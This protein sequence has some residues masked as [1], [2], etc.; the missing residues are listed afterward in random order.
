[1]GSFVGSFTVWVSVTYFLLGNEELAL[2]GWIVVGYVAFIPGI[3]A[4]FLA[5]LVARHF[6][7]RGDMERALERRRLER[8]RSRQK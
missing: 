3:F 4:G 6:L 1:M 2:G 7:V 5:S 8:V